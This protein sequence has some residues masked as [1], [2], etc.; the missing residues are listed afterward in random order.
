MAQPGS[1]PAWHAGGQGFESP[2][3]HRTEKA[4][5]AFADNARNGAAFSVLCMHVAM[6]SP[7]VPA[8]RFRRI[9]LRDARTRV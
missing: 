5:S 7:G 2:W 8:G 6:R 9:V 1:A 3:I 4:A